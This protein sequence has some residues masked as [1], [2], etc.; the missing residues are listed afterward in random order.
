MVLKHALPN[1]F[2][3]RRKHNTQVPTNHCLTPKHKHENVLDIVK[4]KG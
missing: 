2:S 3:L 1:T 4:D